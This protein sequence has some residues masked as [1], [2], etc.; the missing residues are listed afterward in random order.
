MVWSV[1]SLFSHTKWATQIRPL[2][3]LQLDLAIS[4][5]HLDALAWFS[6]GP[7][8]FF[9]LRTH[10]ASTSPAPPRSGPH[11]RRPTQARSGQLATPADPHVERVIVCGIE[12]GGGDGWMETGME[13]HGWRYIRHTHT[14]TH[15]HIY[16]YMRPGW[17][18]TAE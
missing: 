14:H 16:I 11:A 15:T 10:S 13:T 17:E 5:P 3:G 4:P 2:P 6:M 12:R 1:R 7:S 9:P 8:L 18:V